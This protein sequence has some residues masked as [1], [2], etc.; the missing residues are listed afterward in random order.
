[1]KPLSFLDAITRIFCI[2]A[3]LYMTVTI[4]P[5]LVQHLSLWWYHGVL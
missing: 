3:L 1:M 4:L 2:V 5:T